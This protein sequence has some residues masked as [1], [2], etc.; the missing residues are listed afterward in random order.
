MQCLMLIQTQ[1]CIG[2]K[3]QGHEDVGVE[4]FKGQFCYVGLDTSIFLK[5]PNHKSEYETS[6]IGKDIAIEDIP[7][8][9]AYWMEDILESLKPVRA[10]TSHM[11]KF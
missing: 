11:I 6:F 3:S 10:S 1:E 7:R 9:G 5:S 2:T 8:G 4:A